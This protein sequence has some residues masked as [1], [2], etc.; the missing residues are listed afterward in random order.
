MLIRSKR[1]PRNPDAPQRHEHH[2]RPMTRRELL[3]QGYDGSL[4]VG[5][6]TVSGIFQSGSPELDKFVT[7]IPLTVFDEILWR[8]SRTANLVTTR[9]DVF[10]II[11]RAQGG[12]IAPEDIS[13]DGLINYRNDFVITS[14]DQT[15]TVYER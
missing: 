6:F 5:V 4:A 2:A 14:E 3:G 1:K 9:S 12:Y 8:Y 7:Q 13:G 10:E 15:R 11:V